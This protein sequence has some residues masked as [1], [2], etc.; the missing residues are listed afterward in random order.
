[1]KKKILYPLIALMTFFLLVKY[2]NYHSIYAKYDEEIIELRDRAFNFF[3]YTGDEDLTSESHLEMLDFYLSENGG[4]K[5]LED[6]Y[7][8]VKS[9]DKSKYI[10]YVFGK[11]KK[12]NNMNYL[13]LNSFNEREESSFKK[14]SFLEYLTGN[15]RD[16]DV[17]LFEYRNTN[18]SFLYNGSFFKNKTLFLDANGRKV[19]KALLREIIDN[20]Y[21]IEK[22]YLGKNRWEISY[23]EV[24]VKKKYR[25]LFFKIDGQ[26][27]TCLNSLDFSE[28]KIKEL[29]ADLTKS[30][31]KK[32]DGTKELDYG[33]FS[34]LHPG[35]LLDS[36]I[37]GNSESLKKV[38]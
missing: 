6:G 10:F 21:S 3:I 35:P 22:N 28:E 16:Y 20:I 34:I 11:D 36:S 14:P 9:K 15:F 27:I 25:Q 2:Y 19:K 29:E 7:R 18:N 1:M 24:G 8:V 38:K 13:P 32:I 37:V 31:L 33:F 23:K 5:M 4:K 26:M 30:I 17:I 12:D